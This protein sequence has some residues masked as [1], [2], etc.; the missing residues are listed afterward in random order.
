MMVDLNVELY[1]VAHREI[2]KIVV[3]HRGRIVHRDLLTVVAEFPTRFD[4]NKAYAWVVNVL[5]KIGLRKYH[6]PL[7]HE[8]LDGDG[9]KGKPWTLIIYLP[10]KW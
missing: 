6:E 1:R 4:A 10:V 5:R 2:E 9:R 3:E 7:E 8:L